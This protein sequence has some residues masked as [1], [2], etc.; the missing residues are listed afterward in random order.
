[1]HLRVCQKKIRVCKRPER[2][3]ETMTYETNTLY[4]QNNNAE[5]KTDGSVINSDY[6]ALLVLVHLNIITN[7]EHIVFDVGNEMSGANDSVW[8]KN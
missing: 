6:R 4:A 7:D 8:S 3:K 5:L 2:T 1:M